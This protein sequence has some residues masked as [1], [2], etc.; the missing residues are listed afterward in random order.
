MPACKRSRAV[1]APEGLKGLK[2]LRD[3]NRDESG[4]CLIKML[5]GETTG[6]GIVREKEKE[7]LIRELFFFF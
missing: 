5:R 1:R 3:L 7:K 2:G 6:G 4:R